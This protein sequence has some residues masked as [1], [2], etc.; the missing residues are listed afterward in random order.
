MD[1]MAYNKE[2]QNGGNELANALLN[3]AKQMEKQTDLLSRLLL[4]T[5]ASE[6]IRKKPKT[7]KVT[8]ETNGP[9]TEEPDSESAEDLPVNDQDVEIRLEIQT[10][11]ND[12]LA[13]REK[14]ENVNNDNIIAVLAGKSM[15]NDAAMRCFPALHIMAVKIGNRGLITPFKEEEGKDFM[16]IIKGIVGRDRSRMRALWL[17]FLHEVCD[18][19]F[20]ELEPRET[21]MCAVVA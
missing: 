20:N 6:G 12:R 21:G 7:K 8:Q 3:F 19:H 18:K 2:N 11:E 13:R 9:T 17:D 1:S 10:F 4:A 5:E 14:W 15:Y 16:E